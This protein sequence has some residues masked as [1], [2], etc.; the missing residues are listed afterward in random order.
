MQAQLLG[1]RQAIL[2][3]CFLVALL[4]VVGACADQVESHISLDLSFSVTT[5]PGTPKV[6]VEVFIRDR[7]FPQEGQPRRLREPACV[8]DGS[9]HCRSKLTYSYGFGT[10]SW[11]ESLRDFLQG[12]RRFEV[13]VHEGK[14]LI[15]RQL[16][17][18]LSAKQIQGWEVTPVNLELGEDQRP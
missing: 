1:A 2:R 4:C 7:D 10:W 12:G 5:A 11:R 13:A 6:G 14:R 3:K 18:Q 17:P 15:F 16:L 8:T 9:G